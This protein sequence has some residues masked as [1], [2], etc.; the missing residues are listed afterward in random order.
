MTKFIEE[1]PM[2]G[3]EL[4]IT[5]GLVVG[6]TGSDVELA[7]PEVSRR[8]ATFRDVDGGIAVE[9]LG[10]SNGTFVN[11]QPVQGIVT[12]KPGDA[13]R[14]GNTVWRLGGGEGATVA[15]PTPAAAAAPEPA[16]GGERPPTGIRQ[17]LGAEPVYGEALP[18]FDPTR[19]PSPVLGRS[20]ARR[21]EV[22]LYSYAAVIVAA[23]GVAIYFIQR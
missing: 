9:D 4:E 19:A 3:R 7:D 2:A 11:E 10:S 22:T 13:V 14:F 23:G 8:H 20:A 12:L 6:R 21:L 1:K 16:A 15:A 18:T 5:A 17:A